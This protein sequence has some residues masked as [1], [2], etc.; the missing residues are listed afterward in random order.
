MKIWILLGLVCSAQY[1]SA[2]SIASDLN[3]LRQQFANAA[4]AFGGSAPPAVEEPVA[5]PEE[6]PASEPVSAFSKFLSKINSEPKVDTATNLTTRVQNQ[7]RSYPY[8]YPPSPYG[9]YPS[10]YPSPYQSPY[11]PVNPSYPPSYYSD[12]NNR[13]YN[14]FPDGTLYDQATGQYYPRDQR[15]EARI[16]TNTGFG[17]P[18]YIVTPDGGTFVEENGVRYKIDDDVSADG[19][20]YYTDA[21]GNRFYINASGGKVFTPTTTQGP[22]Y[23]DPTGKQYNVQPDGSLI[24]PTTN[25]VYPLNGLGEA[26]VP[27]TSG[28]GD[29]NY[30]VAPDGS[31]YVTQNGIK[32]K[33]DDQISPDGNRYYTDSLGNR[34]YVDANGNKVYP[35]NPTTQ[36]VTYYVDPTGKQYIVQPDGTLKDPTTNQIY[37][38]NAQGEPTAPNTSGFGDPNYAVGPDG[39]SYVTENGIRYKVDDQIS[40]D[41][42]RYYTDAA[43]NR[44]YV[45]PNGLKIYVRPDGV[46]YYTD[47]NNGIVYYQNPD[48]TIYYTGSNGVVYYQDPTNGDTYT[49]D[50]A[51]NTYRTRTDGSSYIQSANGCTYSVNGTV[52]TLTSTTNTS[53]PTS[54]S[55]TSPENVTYT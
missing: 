14:V 20:R 43:G 32:Y 51:G 34:F 40:P 2:A 23:I 16:P 28:F 54:F 39:S 36:G 4:S 25:Q 35:P 31:A 26:S 38:L 42:N 9:G 24:D 19:N 17:A 1:L 12:P 27:N 33:V 22:K 5:T 13:L 18:Y 7:A 30:T 47:P 15:G 52:T 37:P 6:Q 45:D 21:A 53:C 11:A 46:K 55:G 41:G 29:P 49:R 48:G 50:A 10:P 44:F 3:A 8:S